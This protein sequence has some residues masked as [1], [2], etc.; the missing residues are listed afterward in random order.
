M[1]VLLVSIQF[2]AVTINGAVATPIAEEKTVIDLGDQAVYD[3]TDGNTDVSWPVGPDEKTLTSDSAIL[4]DADT[5][6]ILYN[7][8][9]TKKH[10]PASITKILTTLLCVENSSP[11]EV[12]T[13]TADE[14]TNLEYGAS[15]IGTKIGEKLTM[16]QCLYGIMLSSANEVCLGVAD[17]IAGSVEA[18]AEMMNNRARE[19]GCV[20]SHFVNPNG[21][22]DDDHYTCA[23]DMAL[24]GKE[25]LKNET[26]R[27]VAGTKVTY[28][29]KT[30]KSKERTLVNHHNMLYAYSTSDYLNPECIGGKTGYTSVAQSTLVTFAQ[31]DDMTLICVVMQGQ[32]SKTNPSHNIYTDT[33][34]L[35]NYGFDQYQVYSLEDSGDEQT[36]QED[37][38]F[39]T[40]FASILDKEQSPLQTSSSGKVVLPTG[41]KLKQAVQSVT[42]LDGQDGEVE[43]NQIGSVSYTYGNKTV[44]STKI[45]YDPTAG[46]SELTTEDDLT[47]TNSTSVVGESKASVIR[48]RRI[49]IGVCGVILFVI[50]VIAIIRW[51]QNAHLRKHRYST[52]PNRYRDEDL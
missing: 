51:R 49:A 33:Q 50:L 42:F 27:K 15:N 18:F 13:F 21:L 31:R 11:E 17:H 44:G 23:Y 20:N 43:E 19:L 2:P 3:T 47:Y 46:V 52:P 26:F 14:V 8:N 38:P 40:E 48:I 35:L 25:A 16:D 41:V 10:Y 37:S 30:N 45:Y 22:H 5:G 36:E 6:L 28:L 34:S 32:S 29:D 39:F 4:M 9:M 12:V 7:K 24:I 1:L